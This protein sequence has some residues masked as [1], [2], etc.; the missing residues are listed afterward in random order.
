M[1][2]FNVY[3]VSPVTQRLGVKRLIGQPRHAVRLLGNIKPERRFNPGSN[4]R[5]Q[6]SNGEM[7]IE[8]HHHPV[9]GNGDADGPSPTGCA[10]ISDDA[11][12]VGLDGCRQYFYEG[13]EW[14]GR[15]D[16]D[17]SGIWSGILCTDWQAQYCN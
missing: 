10:G 11:H 8:N 9:A 16:Y 6:H 13:V 7:G 14:L 1:T 5:L 12:F 2:D 3:Q 17:C 15:F 4:A